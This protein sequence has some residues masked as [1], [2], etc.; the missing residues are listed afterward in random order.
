MHPRAACYLL[1]VKLNPFRGLDNPRE[2]FAWGLYDLANQSFTLLIITL[3][4]PIYFREIIVGDEQRG[5]ALWGVI[6][7][8]SLVVVVVVSPILGATADGFGLK[9]RMLIGSG[10]ICGILT[11]GLGLLGPGQVGIA[12]ALFIA[13][14]LLYQIGENFLASFLP[15]VSTPRNVGR[16]SATGW[17]MGYV[18][19]LLLL[20]ITAL[21]MLVFR[22]EVAAWSPLF[23][24]AGLWFLAGI[25]MPAVVLREAP[26]HDPEAAERGVVVV[27][28]KRLAQTV[29]NA[30]GYRQLIRF[31]TAFFVYGFGVQVIVYFAGL[32]ARDFGFN[33]T[34]LVLFILQLTVTAGAASAITAKFQDRIGARSTIM[35]YLAVWIVSAAALAGL[36]ILPPETRPEALFWIVGNGIG[37]ALGGIGAA[38]RGMVGRFTPRHKTAEF[39]GLWGM[40]YKLAGVIGVAGFGQVKAWIGDTESM[41][42]LTAFFVGGLL[43]ML[44]VDET[45]GVRAAQRAARAAGVGADMK[46]KAT[47]D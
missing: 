25:I 20:I 5:T 37:F 16:V 47:R 21:A 45:A 41:L 4:F 23:V 7:P 11:C 13:A 15:E 43:L 6:G 3:L 18:G 31:L 28:F 32:I 24:M 34:K 46:R 27:A 19:A 44:R 36:T 29:R 9:K 2:V 38:S 22:L 26:A 39:F 35:I 42:V 30:A 12:V 33:Q 8:V 40:T 17:T 10:I 1:P 14:N